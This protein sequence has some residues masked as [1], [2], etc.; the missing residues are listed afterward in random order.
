MNFFEK[1]I[2]NNPIYKKLFRKRI[3]IKELQKIINED[4]LNEKSFFICNSLSKESKKLFLKYR[5]VAWNYARQFSVNEYTYSTND[6]WWSCPWD[7]MNQQYVVQEK[8]HFIKHLIE[9]LKK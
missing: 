6:P 9:I 5:Y 1:I 4:L 7:Y 8:Y 2:K 3:L